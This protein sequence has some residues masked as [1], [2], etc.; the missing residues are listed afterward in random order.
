MA[1]MYSKANSWEFWKLMKDR[2]LQFQKTKK[3][4]KSKKDKYREK[5]KLL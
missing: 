2:N 5:L 4:Q 3:F 1:E